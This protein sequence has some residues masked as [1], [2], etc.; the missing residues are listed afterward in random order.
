LAR[1]LWQTRATRPTCEATAALTIGPG[2][3]AARGPVAFGSLSGDNVGYRGDENGRGK[4]ADVQPLH[5]RHQ[6]FFPMI[7]ATETDP[8]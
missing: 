5:P 6:A 7:E 8:R 4:P 1:V 3:M 2:A